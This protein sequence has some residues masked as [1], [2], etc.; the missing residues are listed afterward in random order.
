MRQQLAIGEKNLEQADERLANESARVEIAQ[1][2]I[3]LRREELEEQRAAQEMAKG[4]AHASSVYDVWRGLEEGEER[5]KYAIDR[6][7]ELHDVMEDGQAKSTLA[8][9]LED[10]V[11]GSAEMEEFGREAYKILGREPPQTKSGYRTL[12]P[13]EKAFRGI[14]ET[15]FAQID[16]DTG[17][18]SINE[19][20]K[21]REDSPDTSKPIPTPTRAKEEIVS[22]YTEK[23]FDEGTYILPDGEK[24]K[25]DEYGFSSSEKTEVN[26]WVGDTAE[27][28]QRIDAQRN[29]AT[30]YANAAERAVAE[31]SKF[32]KPPADPGF[33]SND[34]MRFTPPPYNI[35]DV[36]QGDDGQQYIV[37]GYNAQGGPKG[38]PVGG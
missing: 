16:Q 2:E 27:R 12:S 31:V 29:R 14:P 3:G 13:E 33:F 20:R 7:K 36:I 9:A 15:S 37:T 6:F 38:E 24:E 19:P 8:K 34:T 21:G 1:E 18:V 22:E 5:D 25:Y 11:I 17:K 32:I 30:G 10:G 35:G 23:L 28:I 4:A 26:R